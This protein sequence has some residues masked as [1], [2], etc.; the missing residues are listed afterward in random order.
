MSKIK[1]LI[2]KVA[3]TRGNKRGS[4]ESTGGNEAAVEVAGHQDAIHFAQTNGQVRPPLQGN[5]Y[6]HGRKLDRSLSMTEERALR[7]EAREAAEERE[8]QR[9]DAEKKKAYDEVC[10]LSHI[11]SS[12]TKL[13]HTQDPMKDNYGDRPFTNQKSGAAYP[14]LRGEAQAWIATYHTHR[15]EVGAHRQ[16]FSRGRRQAD[17][18][19]GQGPS[20]PGDEQAHPFLGPPSEHWDHP[21]CAD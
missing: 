18:L 9:H 4:P 11:P 1:H 2:H 13:E 5:T 16:T 8:K 21:G 3:S 14:Y 7:S 17:S 12:S 10:S 19:Q 6:H 15:T 20:C